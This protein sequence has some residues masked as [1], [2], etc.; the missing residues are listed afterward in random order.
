[1]A[2]DKTE[3]NRLRQRERYK[4]FQVRRIE[5]FKTLG[6]KCQMCGKEAKIGFH[7]HH[8]EYQEES[9]YPRNSKTMSVRWKRL[10]EA[11]SFPERFALLCPYCH[12]TLLFFMKIK[13]KGISL[14]VAITLI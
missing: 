4:D 13:S 2:F 5:V 14:E 11:E 8:T 3:Y 10:K 9:N 6:N 1:M 7:L 12:Q